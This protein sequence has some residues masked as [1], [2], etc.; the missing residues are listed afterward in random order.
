MASKTK[1][2]KFTIDDMVKLSYEKQWISPC[3]SIFPN[4]FG[5]NL[6]SVDNFEFECEDGEEFSQLVSLKVNFKPYTHTKVDDDIC[7]LNKAGSW[8]K[9]FEEWKQFLTKNKK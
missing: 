8:E 3:L 5:I 9:S 7:R 6:C 4:N 2:Y 1:N